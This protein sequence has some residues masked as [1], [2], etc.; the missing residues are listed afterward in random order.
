MDTYHMSNRHSGEIENS[1]KVLLLPSQSSRIIFTHRRTYKE[2]FVK[3]RS[4][5][6]VATFLM[7][8]FL[9]TGCQQVLGILDGGSGASTIAVTGIALDRASL[10][11]GLGATTSLVATVS[12]TTATNKAVTWSSSDPSIVSVDA[13]GTLVGVAPGTATVTAMTSDRS[14]VTS[15]SVAV[16]L[17]I[18]GGVWPT[19]GAETPGYW[20]NSVF[21]PLSYPSGYSQGAEASNVA[22]SGPDTYVAGVAIADATTLSNAM[23][24][25]MQ[26]LNTTS[27]VTGPT[28]SYSG[29]GITIT[30]TVSATDF[31][32][33]YAFSGFTTT[34]GYSIDSGSCTYIGTYTGNFSSP[35]SQ[36]ATIVGTG[37]T[38]TGSGLTSI[39]SGSVNAAISGSS[40]SPSITGS[41]TIN[42]QAFPASLWLSASALSGS[43]YA[44]GYWKNGVYYDLATPDNSPGGDAYDIAVSGSTVSIVGIAGGNSTSA[45]P[46]IW[47]NGSFSALPLP[48]GANSG[49]AYRMAVSG[50]TMYVSGEAYGTTGSIPIYWQNG[51]LFALPLPTGASGAGAYGVSL[52]NGSPVFC[53]YATMSST[54]RDACYWQNGQPYLLTVPSTYTWSR[55]SRIAITGSDIY[56]SGVVRDASGAYLP[57]YW[58]N[59]AFNLL[60]VPSATPTGY[61]Y[62]IAAAGSNFYVSGYTKDASGDWYPAM[63]SNGSYQALPTPAGSPY[64]YGYTARSLGR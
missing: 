1:R 14:E 22:V 26:A 13:N 53:G 24:A 25:F 43:Y 32:L 41:M 27:L 39:T 63:W 2:V 40:S 56:I 10:N 50:S 45:I 49:Y 12:P 18:A 20:A 62:G 59:G 11:L 9:L 15:C 36:N 42:G 28:V 48:S 23:Q 52:L 7:L 5:L 31:N 64:G 35:T 60:Q 29:T 6:A 51:V 21:V 54:V 46:G 57:C 33:T 44:A 19:T 16:T 4:P 37:F 17:Y 61:A 55:A 3:S 47:T 34:S 30:G 58:V 38:M 8:S